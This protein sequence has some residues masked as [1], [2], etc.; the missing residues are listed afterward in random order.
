M[1]WNPA[2]LQQWL[3]NDLLTLLVEDNAILSRLKWHC[4]LPAELIDRLLQC[5][6]IPFQE[7]DSGYEIKIDFLAGFWDG[8]Q[9]CLFMGSDSLAMDDLS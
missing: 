9:L 7:W 6:W 1:E 4:L 3:K 5:S 2:A 8:W